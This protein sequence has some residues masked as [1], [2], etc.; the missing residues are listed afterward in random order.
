M[1]K[2]IAALNRP[3]RL[4]IFILLMGGGAALCLA[5]V[6]VLILQAVGSV[7][8][9]QAVALRDGVTATE[10]FTLEDADAYPASLAVGPDGTVYTASYVTG[11]IWAADSAGSVRELTQT[12]HLLGAVSGMAAAP[13]GTLYVVDRLSADIGSRGGVVFRIGPDGTVTPFGGASGE[14]GFMLPDDIA[15]DARGY[16]YVTDWGRDVVWRLPPEGGE[17]VVWWQPPAI[18]GV[19]DYAPTGIAYDTLRAALIITDPTRD[20]VYLV[21]ALANTPTETAALTQ[22]LY[23]HSGEQTPGFDGVTVTPDGT[24]YL[25]AL[26]INK[27]AR[28]QNGALD[29]LAGSFRGGSDVDY[30]LQADG[31]LRLYVSNWDQLS[32]L[33]KAITPRLPFGID[34]I[35]VAAGQ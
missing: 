4:L 20:T 6:A 19:S 25:A 35:T 18:P 13:D 17:A 31:S 34:V 28:L 16:I 24:I 14:Q 15:R 10:F 1:I 32:L 33:V 27:L 5:L 7:P 22:V 8:R 30:A 3:Q 11:A 12:R 2:R 9:V 21:P 23:Q 26:G 29:Y